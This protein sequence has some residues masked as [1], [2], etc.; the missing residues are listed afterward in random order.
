MAYIR[1]DL[2]NELVNGQTVTFKAPCDCTAIQG[3]RAYYQKDGEQHSATFTLKDTH[4]H[5]LTGIGNLFA[6][7]AYVKATLDT[8]NHFAYLVNADTNK[9]LEGRFAGIE[10]NMRAIFS[11]DPN[12]ATLDITLNPEG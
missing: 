12:T 8:E 2:I 10:E 1:V 3:V 11:F 5:T 9:Y 7:G 4:G 6:A